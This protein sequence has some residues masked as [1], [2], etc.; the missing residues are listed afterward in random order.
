M[1]STYHQTWH[2]AISQYLHGTSTRTENRSNFLG[3]AFL[4]R[5]I[6]FRGIPPQ[7]TRSPSMARFIAPPFRCGA[8]RL[9]SR[10]GSRFRR[11][12]ALNDNAFQPREEGAFHPRK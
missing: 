12:K 7:R 3:G 8:A 6:P 1:K 5:A 4:L 10:E 2:S 9:L 11:W